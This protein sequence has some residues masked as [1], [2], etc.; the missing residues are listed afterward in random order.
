MQSISCFRVLHNDSSLWFWVVL[1]IF[2]TH[3]NAFFTASEL[4]N[5][6]PLT[7]RVVT[8]TVIDRPLSESR[9][10][11]PGPFRTQR[12]HPSRFRPAASL[13]T[14]QQKV[15]EKTRLRDRRL[16]RTIDLLQHASP[17]AKQLTVLSAEISWTH[18]Y[19]H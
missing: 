6:L 5:P 10:D 16:G 1:C 18:P 2:N 4:L 19:R 3:L 12:L 17:W 14:A 7:P 9:S 8:L 15:I 11:P 13:P